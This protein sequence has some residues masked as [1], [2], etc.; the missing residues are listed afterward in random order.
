MSDISSEG[1]D[2]TLLYILDKFS[3]EEKKRIP[4]N[5][6][7]LVLDSMVDYYYDKNLISDNGKEEAEIDEDDMLKFIMQKISTSGFNISEEDVQL[8][9]DLEFDYGKSIGMYK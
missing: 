8:I 3:D 9:L 4:K 7:Q 1:D 6:V 2:E 5:A